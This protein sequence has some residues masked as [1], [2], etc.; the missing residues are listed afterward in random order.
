[1][2]TARMLMRPFQVEKEKR[3]VEGYRLG[4]KSGDTGRG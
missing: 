2:S 3:D 1:M 4:S